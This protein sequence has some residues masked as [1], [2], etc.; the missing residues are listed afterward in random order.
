MEA[1]LAQA[2]VAGGMTS[3]AAAV[4][5]G[6]LMSTVGT[7]ASVVSAGAG[8]LGGVQSAQHQ[9]YAADVSA[10][11]MKAQAHQEKLRAQEEGNLRR[12]RLL[13]ALAS[14]S[15][16]AG[17]GGVKGSTTEAL[18]LES[19][20]D[21]QREQQGA[22]LMT[23]LEQSRLTSGAAATKKAGKYQRTGSLLKLGSQLAEI[24]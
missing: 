13:K 24:G 6:S 18:K 12:E 5:A 2:F 4:Q 15:A 10:E 19:V 1:A 8:I 11:G 14:Q 16:Y 22:D 23:G 21:F 20:K 9:K 3:G 17:A 7:V